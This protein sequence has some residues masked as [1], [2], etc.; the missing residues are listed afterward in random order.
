MTKGT[1][2]WD[3]KG[4]KL[5]FLRRMAW[6]SLGQ[7]TGN[8][9]LL[10]H[11]NR[12]QLWWH[13]YLV[14]SPRS[15]LFSPLPENPGHTGKTM[16]QECL[17]IPKEEIEEVAMEKK[18]ILLWLLPPWPNSSWP[19]DNR[20]IGNFNIFCQQLKTQILYISF[21]FGCKSLRQIKYCNIMNQP[22]V[23]L[24]VWAGGESSQKTKLASPDS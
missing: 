13:K 2:F 21:T 10:L 14:L 24:P 18:G 1:R 20:S 19:Q 12:N 7:V 17:R 6:R 8:E 22:L 5:S 11:I 4:P 3:T 9:S 23:P 15:L 16:P